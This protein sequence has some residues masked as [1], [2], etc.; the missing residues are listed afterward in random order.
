M[1]KIRIEKI[2]T[3]DKSAVYTKQKRHCVYLGNR[4]SVY[5]SDM[6]KAKAFLVQTNEFLNQ[7]LYEINSL[8]I[9]VFTEYRKA[10]FYFF[11]IYDRSLHIVSE[12]KILMDIGAIEKKM[13]LMVARSHFP[14]GSTIVHQGF[15][16]I[17]DVLMD[18]TDTLILLYKQKKH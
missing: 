18:I 6:K 2:K 17:I 9:E 7:K 14:N 12:N 16:Y 11:D 15:S 5:F 3:G 1:K 4:V 10:W 13:S 8:Y